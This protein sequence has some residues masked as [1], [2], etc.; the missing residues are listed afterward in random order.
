MTVGRLLG[1]LAFIATAGGALAAFPE[2]S[3]ATSYKLA[4]SQV[5]DDASGVTTT[6]AENAVCRVQFS[7]RIDEQVVGLTVVSI[8]SPGNAY[9]RFESGGKPIAIGSNGYAHIALGTSRVASTT[10]GIQHPADWTYDEALG[11]MFHWP[12]VRGTSPLL[13]AVHATIIRLD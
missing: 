8:F 7:V 4:I 12:V 5:A 2:R 6:C 1:T 3:W 9:V 10:I 13:T 11:S